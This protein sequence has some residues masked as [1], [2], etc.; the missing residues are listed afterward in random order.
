MIYNLVFIII[1]IAVVFFTAIAG[2]FGAPSVPVPKEVAKKMASLMKIKKQR[3]Y[4]DLGSGDGRILRNVARQG[5]FAFGFELAPLTYIYSRMLFLIRPQKKVR[6]FW[7]NFWKINLK[8]TFGVFCY[9]MPIP[10]EKLDK[11]FKEELRSG[12]KVISYAFG[13]PGKEPEKVIKMKN[14]A[15]IYLY[16]Y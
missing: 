10:M 9:L 12:T 14:Y 16:R 1:L 7:K 5:A 15:P 4:Y 3:I 2:F 11:K 13:I 8:N 6:I